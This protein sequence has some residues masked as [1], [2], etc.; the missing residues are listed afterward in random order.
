MRVS[1]AHPPPASPETHRRPTA[2]F[3]KR[4]D[5]K[6]RDSDGSHLRWNFPV[7]PL[8]SSLLVNRASLI[9]ALFS[10]LW[11]T[12]QDGPKIT[13][14]TAPKNPFTIQQQT[15]YPWKKSITATVFWIGEKPTPGNPT[16]N[17]QSSWDVNW[18]EN[19][20]GFDNPDPDARRGYLPPGFIPKQNPFYVA[21]PYNDCLNHRLHKPEAPRVIPWW[22]RLQR[23]PG[24]SACKGRWVQIYCPETRKVCYAQWEDCGPF[25]TDDWE[26]VFGNKPPK[27]KNNQGAGI[28]I[29]PAVRDYLGTGNK[30]TVHWRFVEFSKVPQSGPWA[31]HGTN[32]PF[33]NKMVDDDLA[34]RSRYMD[35]LDRLRDQAR[36][37]AR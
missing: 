22:S 19:Y 29:S 8:P 11:A 24:E 26:Y 21:L 18:Q 14:E 28:D 10:S 5:A 17:N 12:A 23:N 16:P 20:G 6:G 13:V 37:R 7:L 32:N 31:Q 33:L 15:V 1:R 35:Y 34:E 4:N 25:V 9:F 3:A 2:H 27:N 36:R 30:A